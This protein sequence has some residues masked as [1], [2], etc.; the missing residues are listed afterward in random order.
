MKRLPVSRF[1]GGARG[2]LK[3][4]GGNFWG[5]GERRQRGGRGICKKEQPERKTLRIISN[6]SWGGAIRSLEENHYKRKERAFRGRRKII[7]KGSEGPKKEKH[8]RA[9]LQTVYEPNLKEEHGRGR[10]IG[11]LGK[12]WD[13]LWEVLQGKGI[14]DL[15]ER[16]GHRS[17]KIRKYVQKMREEGISF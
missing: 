1:T 9:E 10:E 8:G 13:A 15:R 5:E 3:N 14:E 16:Q 17:M 12:E 7:K 11:G 2:S 6:Q 4:T